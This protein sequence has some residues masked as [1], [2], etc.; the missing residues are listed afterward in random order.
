MNEKRR[1]LLR[2]ALVL[3][4]AARFPIAT[5]QERAALG[6]AAALN[7]AGRQR[8][9]A[10]RAAK[11][12]VMRGLAWGVHARRPIPEVLESLARHYRVTRVR[13]KLDQSLDYVRQGIPWIDALHRAGL[14]RAS[15][16]AVLRAAERTG[17]VEWAL[18][19]Q[20]ASS[21]RRWGTGLKRML[22]ILFPAAIVALG[23]VVG[24]IGWY[25]FAVLSTLIEK[26]A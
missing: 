16:A 6:M 13:W 18:R 17:N 19:E 4:V 8:M 23:L 15:D 25:F 22:T 11:A 24:Q 14:L 20:A 26:L 1:S 10:Q 3:G 12:W 5:A 2:Y 21:S 9:L 7:L